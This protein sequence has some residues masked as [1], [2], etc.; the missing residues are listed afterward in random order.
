ML[1][2]VLHQTCFNYWAYSSL[3]QSLW[4]CTSQLLLQ[5]LW[6]WQ[7]TYLKHRPLTIH[8][9]DPRIFVTTRTFCNL[10]KEERAP[11]C[12]NHPS[13]FE[14]QIPSIIFRIWST[15]IVNHFQNL[16]RKYCPSFLHEHTKKAGYEHVLSSRLSLLMDT[17]EGPL[18]R[19]PFPFPGE[20]YATGKQNKCWT[21][22]CEWMTQ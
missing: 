16:N 18:T 9:L 13:E 15:N 11:I 5:N 1:N 12:Q 22:E 4:R 17:S 20:P 7:K 14:L 19:D 3:F 8:S 6:Q 21:C 10:C 2:L